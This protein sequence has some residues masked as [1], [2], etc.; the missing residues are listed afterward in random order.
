MNH[1][2]LIVAD[3]QAFDAG[4]RCKRRGSLDEDQAPLIEE[5]C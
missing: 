2:L 3:G 4:P 5:I 1:F